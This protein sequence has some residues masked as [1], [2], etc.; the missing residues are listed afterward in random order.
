MGPSEEVHEAGGLVKTELREAWHRYS[1]AVMGIGAAQGADQ[2][3]GLETELVLLGNPYR[4]DPAQGLAVQI[5]YRDAPRADAQIE[6]FE[7]PLTGLSR[8]L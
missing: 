7:K 3:F 2:R 4:E 8:C 1:K 6:I 5:L